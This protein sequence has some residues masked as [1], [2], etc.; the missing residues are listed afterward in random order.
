MEDYIY[1]LLGIVWIVYAAYRSNQK[2]KKAKEKTV[3]SEPLPV[4][5]EPDSE[6]STL[7]DEF[8]STKTPQEE[9]PVFVQEESEYKNIERQHR[10]NDDNIKTDYK[11]DSIPHQE[12]ERIFGED[13]LK[14]FFGH[15][16]ITGGYEDF[17]DRETLDFDL[18]KAII[19][20]EILNRPNF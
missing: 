14:D 16:P 17:S 3:T 4:A 5:S 7:L 18:R 8:F 13:E 9:S 2:K 1:I 11:L 6:F 10:F 15:S 12:G 20:S 19:Y